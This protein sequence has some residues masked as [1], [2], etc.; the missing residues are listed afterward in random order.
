[1][2]ILAIRGRN[3]ASLAEPFEIDLAAEPL[4]GTGLFAIT[5]DTGAGKSTILDAL[6]LA[7][8]GEYPRSSLEQRERMTDPSGDTVQVADAK[9]ILRRG[10]GEGHAEVDFIG[11]DGLG[12]RAR[13]QVRR[14]RNRAT[15][16]LQGV[17][18]KLELLETGEAIATGISSV[19]DAVIERSGFTFEEFRRSVLLAQGEFD[20]FLLADEA[21]RAALL[22]KITGTAIYSRISVKV[23]EGTAARARALEAAEQQQLAVGVLDEAARREIEADQ[24]ACREG[25][26]VASAQS[27]KLRAIIGASDAVLAAEAAV[28][29][30]QATQRSAILAWEL[31]AG[32]R[33]QL[34]KLEKAQSVRDPLMRQ[35]QAV[36][37]R[38]MAQAASAAAVSRRAEAQQAHERAIDA[39]RA[40]QGDVEAALEERSRLEPIWDAAARLDAQVARAVDDLKSAEAAARDAEAAAAKLEQVIAEKCAALAPAEIRR[41]AA[42]QALEQDGAGALLADAAPRIEGM[43]AAWADAMQRLRKVQQAQKQ[44]EAEIL[45]IDRAL[46]TFKTEIDAARLARDDAQRQRQTHRAALASIDRGRLATR[47]ETLGMCVAQLQAVGE[48]V[49]R[50]DESRRGIKAAVETQAAGKAAGD[51]IEADLAARRQQRTSLAAALA[52]ATGLADLARAAIS[53]QAAAMRAALIDG[54]PCPVCGARDHPHGS[55]EAVHRVATA[56]VHRRRLLEQEL[57]DLDIAIA[58]LRGDLTEAAARVTAAREAGVRSRDAEEYVVG[59]LVAAM[60]VL[61]SVAEPLGLPSIAD[62]RPDTVSIEAVRDLAEAAGLERRALVDHRAKAEALARLIDETESRLGDLDARL[63]DLARDTVADRD[64]RQQLVTELA[65]T[66]ATMSAL[67]EQL[68]QAQSALAPLLEAAGLGADDLHRDA[69]AARRRLEQRAATH[70][71]AKDELRAAREAVSAIERDIRDSVLLKPPAERDS[72]DKRAL[73]VQ[74]AGALDALRTER[75][76]FLGGAAVGDHRNQFQQRLRDLQ[77]D[78]DAARQAEAGAGVAHAEARSQAQALSAAAVAAASALAAAVQV[79][80]TAL[81]STGLDGD[82]VRVLLATKDETRQTLGQRIADLEAARQASETRLDLRR[83]DLARLTATGVRRISV[84]E[85]QEMERQADALDAEA[86]QVKGRLAVITDRLTRDAAARTKA[87]EMA[88]AIARQRNEHA[89][90]SAVNLAIGAATGDKFR[91]IAQ[92][93]TLGQL[94]A[95]ANTQ[96]AFLGPR[97]R[98]QRGRHPEHPL[99]LEIVDRDMGDEIRSPRSLSGGERFIVSLALALALSGIE[100]RQSFVD[101]L[102]IDEGFGSLDRETL[103]VVI[104]ALETL[105]GQGRKVGVITHVPAMMEQ[106]AVQVRVERRGGG[107]SV[108]RVGDRDSGGITA[109]A[110]PR[111]HAN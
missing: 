15:G 41:A 106:I 94:I 34:A 87:S 69:G 85:R 27:A 2:R 107:Q 93:V 53:D 54:E 98:L 3:L 91:K 36:Q 50:R 62:W 63:E 5:G 17:E 33:D 40:V 105:H 13:W 38:E 32:D 52:E 83:N 100:G 68:E 30:A 78:L 79:V 44:A 22:E 96:L 90:W 110:V 18:R 81:A 74:R 26:Q 39:S 1:M 43:V 70:A 58:T 76:G 12:Y 14:A 57:A 108:V 64:R 48:L 60:Q 35:D 71:V 82:G 77:I 6:C 28:A 65:G 89:V 11:V 29:E 111:R 31:A 75:A 80:A 99:A 103:D 20:A 10:A 66:R 51:R 95:I 92:G 109:G 23:Y 73:A 16:K 84:V 37:T 101:T 88:E 46:E 19:R 49:Q 47:D 56:I 104:G 25:L 21:Q 42:E 55:D 4:A 8:Y 59:S 67:E 72:R 86:D 61:H 24:S 45:R 102:F 7:L 97:Y 9:N